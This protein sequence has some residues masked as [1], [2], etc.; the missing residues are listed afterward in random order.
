MMQ[1]LDGVKFYQKSQHGYFVNGARTRPLNESGSD[2]DIAREGDNRVIDFRFSQVTINKSGSNDEVRNPSNS[3]VDDYY[4]V[5]S[6]Y[7]CFL[8]VSSSPLVSSCW[9]HLSLRP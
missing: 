4:G 1:E 8:S 2:F 6:A 7:G 5:S 9:Y 3:D